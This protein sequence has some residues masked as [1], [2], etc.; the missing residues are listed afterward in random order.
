M[1][2]ISLNN[3]PKTFKFKVFRFMPRGAEGLIEYQA[4]EDS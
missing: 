2:T 4:G 1:I 3:K